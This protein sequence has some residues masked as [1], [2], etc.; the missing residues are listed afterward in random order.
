MNAIVIPCA[1]CGTKNRIPAAKLHLH[2]RCGKCKEL[3]VVR[4]EDVVPV[5]LDDASFHDFVLHASLPVVVDFYS[6]TC[7]H[8]QRI[9]PL[10]HEL[11]GR[12]F[13][14]VIIATFD[15]SRFPTIPNQFQIRGVPTLIFFKAGQK[16]ERFDGA[17]AE[18]VLVQTVER[19][20]A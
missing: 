14:R 20:L 3:I 15:T 7:G 16:M 18:S 1:H 13:Q 9:A 5:N 10:I 19:L 2:P 6:P 11:A 17:V 12:Y 4:R 8:C